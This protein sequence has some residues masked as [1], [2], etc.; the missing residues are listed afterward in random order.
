MYECKI[1]GFAIPVIGKA[2][3]YVY[4]L[5]PEAKCHKWFNNFHI[6]L[7]VCR[8]STSNL[9]LSTWSASTEAQCCNCSRIPH[10]VVMA[11]VRMT[12][13]CGKVSSFSANFNRFA[14]PG[15]PSSTHTLSRVW[16]NICIQTVHQYTLK[17]LVQFL[18]IHTIFS[19][20]FNM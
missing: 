10:G 3:C 11:T 6:Y 1:K 12:S 7:R 13:V 4:M 18:N 20:I 15:S 8:K 19:L 2:W 9:S 17:I 5:T 16:S 14:W